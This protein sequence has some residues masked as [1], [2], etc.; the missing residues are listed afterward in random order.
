MNRSTLKRLG[1][2]VLCGLVGLAL[3]SVQVGTTAP[4]VFGRLLTLPVA[5]LFGPWLGA[6]AAIPPAF[7]GRGVFTAGIVLLPIEA[8]VVGGFAR[9]GRSPI[10]GGFIV[11]TAVAATLIAVPSVYGIGYLRR[12]I[13]PAA[14]Q[15]GVSGLVAVVVADILAHAA[16][17]YL[18]EAEQRSTRRLRSD[19][20]RAFVL[21]AMLP[22]LLLAAV[23]G[24]LTTARQEAA[25]G[26]RLH[27]AAAALGEHIGTYVNDHRRAVESLA[28]TLTTRPLEPPDRQRLLRAYRD[29]YP[30]FITLFIANSSGAVHEIEPRRAD[31]VPVSERPYFIDAA[32]LR[33]TIV[34]D[35]I[36][37]LVTRV[38]TVT[39]GVPFFESGGAVAGVVGGSLDLSRFE[40]F[41]NDLDT[42]PDA[43]I[44]LLDDQARV[45][46][47]SDRT[48]S[49]AL[50]NLG[51]DG[52]VLSSARAV[53][54]IFQYERN[55]PNVSESPR[56]AAYATMPQTGWKSLRRG[57]VDQRPPAV[58][59]LLRVPDGADAARPVRRAAG[60]PRVRRR[61]HAA[62]RRGG[63]RG[64]QHLGPRR[65]RR[66]SPT[67]L[68]PSGRDRG[69][70]RGRQPH[71]DPARGVLYAA[72]AGAHPARGSERRAARPH[73]RSRP[74]G[75]RTDARARRGD[76]G[77][78]RSEPGQ[79]RIPRE[80]E[81]RDPHAAQR[82][83]RNDRS[84]HWTPN[85]RRNSAST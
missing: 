47:A 59:W 73:R 42:M 28:S 37:G 71:A 21:A 33:R 7:S 75:P 8:L 51:Q 3:N 15:I 14:L 9:R 6:L 40:Q 36:V 18:V 1:L 41:K 10:L 23:E 68:E 43:S 78:R 64:P 55:V 4:F 16:A 54:G 29:I 35:V 77:S 81:P 50:Q 32:R 45:I 26:A 67:H 46:Y 58:G 39:I 24:Q 22:V 79:E 63:G 66:Q 34:S 48:R 12:T 27:E 69:A 62:A 85:F 76:A 83:H 61:R 44:T 2:T 57:T 25:G 56:L 52:L 72:R 65:E 11:W 82:R 20:F 70:P 5:I 31:P 30:G 13:L 74:E 38:P 53:N 60:R 80:H 17:P 49:A 19:A 84:S